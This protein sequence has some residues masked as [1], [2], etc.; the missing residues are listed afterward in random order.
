MRITRRF[1]RLRIGCF[2]IALLVPF[3]G[4]TAEGEG[5]Q[6]LGERYNK[7]ETKLETSLQELSAV[8]EKISEEK[9]PL[10]RKLSRQE[11]QLREV[12][13]EY[14]EVRRQLDNRNLKLNNLRET[15][16]AR[17][18]EKT[19]LANLLGEYIRNLETQLHVVEKQYFGDGIEAAKLAL[20]NENMATL[21]VFTTQAGLVDK[22]IERIDNLA[23]GTRFQ[24]EAVGSDGMVQ[25]GR[26]ALFGPVAY[27]M[28]EDGQRA[29]LAVERLGSVKPNLVPFAQ[30]AKGGPFEN[31]KATLPFWGQEE[32]EASADERK[33]DYT[34]M[35]R[36]T[37]SAGR[38]MLPLDPTLGNAHKIAQ[39]R[40]TVVD[41]VQKGGMVAY[42]I[43]LM[44][45]VA[46]L[47]VLV[48]MIQLL[49][50]RMPAQHKIVALL[51][52]L[53]D[54]SEEDAAASAA[55]IKGPAGGMLR[56]A[57]DHMNEPRELVE[58]VMYENIL[59]TRLR[60]QRALPFIAVCA[61]S[62]PLLGL[63]GTVTGIIETFKL[64]TVF[65]SGDVKMLSGGISEAL[66]TTEL[67]L[68]V[69]ILS[70]LAYA[71]LNRRAKAIV[72]RLE[73][74][75]VA[76]M[77]QIARTGGEDVRIGDTVLPEEDHAEAQGEPAPFK[78]E[79]EPTRA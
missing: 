62:A 5:K 74:I 48:K 45:A 32:D 79:P 29:G 2:G 30:P 10:S 40:D 77:N 55:T 7:I 9:L 1:L 6:A 33:R 67:G 69:A 3:S 12:R 8:R 19:Y 14:D 52:A 59:A 18:E 20:D 38:G 60:L 53:R 47:L 26:F 73:K 64:I 61:S 27:F 51:G 57:V 25:Q 56:D 76:V 31:M 34:A 54:G 37:V 11:K 43:L 35:T 75:A 17:K 16:K 39:T 50:V 28:T 15:M 70:L 24:G 41:H 4:M 71:F 36:K 66:I 72:D 13:N 23:G 58:E 21:D 63:L 42:A 46:L 22:S 49:V 65:G 78:K 68:I 44:A